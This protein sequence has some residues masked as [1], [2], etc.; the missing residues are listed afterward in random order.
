[1]EN[2]KN[3]RTINSIKKIAIKRHDKWED[4]FSFLF[5]SFFMS[6]SLLSKLSWVGDYSAHNTRN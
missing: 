2:P 6:V 3:L 4:F 5:F 1:M